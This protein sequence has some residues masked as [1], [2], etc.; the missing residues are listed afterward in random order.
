MIM[1]SVKLA[2]LKRWR[3]QSHIYE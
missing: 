2:R 3:L 1:L